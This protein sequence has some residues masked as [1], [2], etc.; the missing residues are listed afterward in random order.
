MNVIFSR[1]DC[2]CIKKRPPWGK[3]CAGRKCK[4][5]LKYQFSFYPQATQESNY[6]KE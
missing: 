1:N 6:I 4:K 5:F 3:F 2:M